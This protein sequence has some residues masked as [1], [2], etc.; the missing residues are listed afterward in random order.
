LFVVKICGIT[1]A[2]DARMAASAGADAIGLNFYQPSSRYVSPAR[3]SS[4]V[5]DL[6]PSV[7]KVGVFVELSAADVMR[8]S[9]EVGLDIVQL[10]GDESPEMLDR[11]RPMRVIRAFRV[12]D[13]DEETIP[14]YLDRCQ[15]LK[16]L[17]E[18]ILLDAFR[19]GQFGGTGATLNWQSLTGTRDLLSEIPMVLAGGLTADNV[20]QAIETIGPDAVDT[21]SGV[22]KRPGEKDE[23]LVRQFVTAARCALH[24]D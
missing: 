20:I 19:P 9:N 22:E 14:R 15:Q 11:L 8:I 21:A 10:H 13:G 23:S 6:P 1:T 16:C 7:A 3:A 2:T 5:R 17:P 18:A 24:I 12:R 4:I